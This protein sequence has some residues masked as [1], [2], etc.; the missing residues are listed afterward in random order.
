MNVVPGP[1]N[2]SGISF[3][4]TELSTDQYTISKPIPNIAQNVG[5][6]M[7]LVKTGD[8]TTPCSKLIKV[9]PHILVT[10]NAGESLL[11]ISFSQHT[12]VFGAH[13]LMRNIVLNDAVPDHSNNITN[14]LDISSNPNYNIIQH[15]PNPIAVVKTKKTVL[16]TKHE[17]VLSPFVAKQLFELATLRKEMCPITA[18][19]FSLGHTAVMP[20]GHLFM[21]MAIEESFKKERNKCPWCRQHGS[22]TYI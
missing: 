3:V 4:P 16:T 18:E 10:N 21:Q 20:C 7:I 8:T 22:P 12:D 17:Y 19:E 11:V 2:T 5:R 13:K 9:Y 15:V 14:V 1:P 6:M